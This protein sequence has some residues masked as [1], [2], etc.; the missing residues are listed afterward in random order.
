MSCQRIALPLVMLTTL[1]GTAQARVQLPNGELIPTPSVTCGN[2]KAAGLAAIF[3]CACTE[4]GVCNQGKPCPGD[5]VGP[6]DE[7][8]NGTCES[9]IWHDYNGNQCIPE[10]LE[11]LDPVEDAAV[12]PETFKPVCGHTFTLLTRGTATF[13]NAFGWY[14][15]V[16]G[17]KPEPSEMYTMISCDTPDGSKAT[18]ELTTDPRYKGGEVGFFLA[19]PESHQESGRCDGGDCCA[20]V[21]RAAAGQGRL[22]F[23]Q[24]G[25][26]PDAG[27][28]HLLIYNSKIDSHTFYFAWEDTY[29]GHTTDYSDFVTSVSGISCA[30]A[31]VRCD[32]KR[33]GICAQG[34]TRC[35]AEGQ[36][37]CESSIK[38]SNE[39]CD[40]L[41]NDCDGVVDNGA[42]CEAGTVC[43]QG[44]CVKKCTAGTEFPCRTGYQCDRE[45]GTCIDT[46]CRGKTCNAGE[47]CR[48][49]A[50]GNGCEEVICP[51][52]QLCAAGICVDPCKAI[53]CAVGEVCKL[54]VC[55]T[56]C[57][58]CGGLMCLQGERCDPLGGDCYSAT[59]SAPCGAGSVCKEGHCVALCEGVRCPGDAACSAGVCAPPGVGDPRKTGADFSSAHLDGPPSWLG[60]GGVGDGGSRSGDGPSA[61]YVKKG[62]SVSGSGDGAV[63]FGLLLFFALAVLTRR[64]K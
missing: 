43:F 62:C 36:L 6:C 12:K 28:V 60:D 14:N 64:R 11:G 58:Q 44:S 45:K 8:R 22:Y 33:P 52:G 49:G 54:G 38:P 40:G 19:T 13:K 16:A 47:I 48:R 3:A 55:I 10:N 39:V 27:W 53:Q 59:C 17:K 9:R 51:H 4:T 46:L 32:T 37:S 56:S 57:A 61:F 1:A 30:G 2:G 20:T 15:V 25:Y 18:L 63:P 21:E 35:E 29:Q 26:N 7:G 34:I 24:P 31:G 42:S 41:D 50:C 23:S 5:W